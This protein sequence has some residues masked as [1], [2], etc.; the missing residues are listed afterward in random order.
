MLYSQKELKSFIAAL[1]QLI[2]P[3]REIDYD[4]ANQLEI[5]FIQAVKESKYF[6]KKYQNDLWEAMVQ[7]IMSIEEKGNIFAKW[8][9]KVVS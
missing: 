3:L 4:S 8:A 1:A 9:K 2:N 7:L 5:V 6:H